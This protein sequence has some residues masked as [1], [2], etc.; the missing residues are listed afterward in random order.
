MQVEEPAEVQ[1]TP[2]HHVKSPRFD[3][4]DMLVELSPLGQKQAGLFPSV[5]GQ[6]ESRSKRLMST[7]D[8]INQRM[9][10]G[11]IRLASDGIEQNWKMKAGRKSPLYD[12]MGSQGNGLMICCHITHSL[13]RQSANP[14]G[15][16]DCRI[17]E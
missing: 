15:F 12:P 14:I 3:G 10:N 11:T 5:M 4:Q 1:I 2:I 6:D 7:L 9:G 17:S 16:A 8:R 13:I